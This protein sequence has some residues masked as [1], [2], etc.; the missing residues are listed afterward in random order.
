MASNTVRFKMPLDETT[1]VTG[2]HEVYKYDGLIRLIGEGSAEDATGSRIDTFN[3]EIDIPINLPDDVIVNDFIYK[4]NGYPQINDNGHSTVI[5][6]EGVQYNMDQI[7]DLVTILNSYKK[8]YN[9]WPT[10]KIRIGSWLFV[11]NGKEASYTVDVYSPMLVCTSEGKETRI[12]PIADINSEHWIPEGFSG[13]YQLL[14]EDEADDDFT[15]I[16]S[17]TSG[18][19]LSSTLALG[20]KPRSALIQQIRLN[21]RIEIY[22]EESINAKVELK[23]IAKNISENNED[24]VYTVIQKNDSLTVTN[25]SA[26]FTDEYYTYENIMLSTHEFVIKLNNYIAKYHKFP[27]LNIQISTT[28]AYNSE[29]DASAEA[30][31]SQVFL[32][33]VLDKNLSLGIY[34]K[35][36][37]EQRP[38]T[39]AFKKVNGSWSEIAEDEAKTILKNNTIR[40]G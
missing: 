24:A 6:F 37:G 28:G 20:P 29:K 4:I 27:M 18:T 14:S 35:V 31:V 3:A 12:K 7:A 11:P 40:R 16:R 17:G 2:D 39:T 13:I 32:D 26:W 9:T 36:G 30:K 19:T 15:E 22:T 5:V 10:V 1:Q 38:V 34:D 8:Q 33:L 21:S 25:N 23:I